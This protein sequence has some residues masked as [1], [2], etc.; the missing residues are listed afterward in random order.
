MVT[1]RGIEFNPTQIK[2]VLETPASSKK[3]EL[4]CLT[5]RLTI[6]GRFIAHFTDKLRPFFL[7]LNRANTFS[8]TDECRQA[9]E[10]VKRYLTEPLILSSLKSSKQLCM[11]LVAMML[12]VY[13]KA[14]PLII[15]ELVCNTSQTD[16]GWMLN[17]MKYLQAGEVPGDKKQAHKLHEL[18]HIIL[19]CK[20]DK[21]NPIE[22]TEENVGRGKKKVGG[23]ATQSLMGLSDNIRAANMGHSFHPC[24]WDRGHYSN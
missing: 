4:Q 11:Y 21:Q 20:G 16:L 23:Q 9:F 18:W 6:L 3:K 5:S 7:M 15:L 1:Q 17:I 8:W 14:I 19:T 10:V 13:L 22:C 24:L 2:V 12:P